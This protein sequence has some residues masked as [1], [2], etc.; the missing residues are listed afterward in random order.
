MI[1]FE[2]LSEYTRPR[3]RGHSGITPHH[4]TPERLLPPRPGAAAAAAAAA[5]RP[6]RSHAGVAALLAAH[7]PVLV[8]SPSKAPAAQS[9][10]VTLGAFDLSAT[11]LSESL[12]PLA[13]AG[14]LAQW[15]GLTANQAVDEEE[16][17]PRATASV[18][19]WIRARTRLKMA[20]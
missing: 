14:S 3:T 1:M 4:C 18:P 13:V 5:A 15:H 8:P 11:P 7:A 20:R 9:I 6:L 2:K 17:Y 12:R 19:A 10:L 16:G